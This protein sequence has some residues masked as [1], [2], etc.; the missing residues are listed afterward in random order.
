VNLSKQLV[1]LIIKPFST[2]FLKYPHIMI[3]FGGVRVRTPDLIYINYALSLSSELNLWGNTYYDIKI[4]DYALG[5][6]RV[7]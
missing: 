6:V 3:F 1:T 7:T 2:Y 4:A 5:L